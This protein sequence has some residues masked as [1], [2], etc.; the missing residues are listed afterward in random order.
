MTATIRPAKHDDYEAWLPLWEGYNAFYNRA[1]P[2]A[3]SDEVTKTLWSRFF[4]DAEPVY[5]LVAENEDG[6]LL[7][8][9]HYLL[10]RVTASI[11]PVCYLNDLFTNEDSRGKGVGRALIEATYGAARS[12]DCD[13]VYWLT[14]ETNS[15]ARALYDRVGNLSGFIMYRHSL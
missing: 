1:G 14:Q 15:T 11:S 6:Q 7:G 10:H 12:L 5:A 3:V 2:T 4:D 9:S 13:R 8:L